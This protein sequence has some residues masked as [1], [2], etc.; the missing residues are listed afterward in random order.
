[1]QIRLSEAIEQLREELRGAVV[2]GRG[3]DIVFTPQSVEVELAISFA[4]ELKAGGGVKILAFLDLS[5]EAKTGETQAHKVTLKFD[6]E[7]SKGRPLKV[8]DDRLSR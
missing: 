6:V 2:E 3:K 4:T 8:H 7:D 5:T 1:M